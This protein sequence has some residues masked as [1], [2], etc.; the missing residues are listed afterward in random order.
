MYEMVEYG[1]NWKS[2]V[3]YFCIISSLRIIS[4]CILGNTGDKTSD[5]NFFFGPLPYQ[6]SNNIWAEKNQI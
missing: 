4:A 6:V 2:S 1:V 3:K 5:T